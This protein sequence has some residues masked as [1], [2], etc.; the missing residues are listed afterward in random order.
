MP[1]EPKSPLNSPFSKGGD[2]AELLWRSPFEKGGFKNRQT[3]RIYG[4][5]YN[6]KCLGPE[7]YLR[8]TPNAG[9]PLPG[10]RPP[11]KE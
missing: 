11:G 5:C 2:L 3:E 4:K 8:L 10:S 9:F 1:R 7:N 6:Q